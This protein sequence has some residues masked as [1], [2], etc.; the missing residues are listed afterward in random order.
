VVVVRPATS[1]TTMRCRSRS[2]SKIIRQ[3]PTRGVREAV[4]ADRVT[5]E[6]IGGQPV[7]LD[8]ESFALVARGA[9]DVFLGARGD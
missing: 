6:R 8:E 5:A 9:P 3:S 1:V 2:A 7:E 4:E